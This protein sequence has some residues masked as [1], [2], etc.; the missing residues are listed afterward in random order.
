MVLTVSKRMIFWYTAIGLLSC[1]IG[2]FA[3]FLRTFSLFF[4]SF[5]FNFIIYTHISSKVIGSDFYWTVSFQSILINAKMPYFQMCL[6]EISISSYY[7]Y[8]DTGKRL[9]KLVSKF[10]ISDRHLSKAPK[11]YQIYRSIYGNMHLII[12]FTQWATNVT[13]TVRK[14]NASGLTQ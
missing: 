10:S 1:S 8:L 14:S 4:W 7:F 2:W 5:R 9:C 6:C 11:I 13:S 3:S 12:C